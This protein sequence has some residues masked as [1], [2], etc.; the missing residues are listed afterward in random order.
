MPKVI[1][2]NTNLTQLPDK[3][4][5]HLGPIP[6]EK[7]D[8]LEDF[9]KPP[10]FHKRARTVTEYPVYVT[11]PRQYP[12]PKVPNKYEGDQKIERFIDYFDHAK[13]NEK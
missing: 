1:A 6:K 2:K 13:N 12:Y 9:L 5:M 7:I 10:K 11:D 4:K 8:K 3:Y